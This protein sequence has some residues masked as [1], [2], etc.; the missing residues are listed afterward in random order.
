MMAQRTDELIVKQ[1]TLLCNIVLLRP[2]LLLLQVTHMWG[3]KLLGESQHSECF[4]SSKD[5][6]FILISFLTNIHDREHQFIRTDINCD[7][8]FAEP[9]I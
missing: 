2:I 8:V 6:V 4:S 9:Q 7:N 3:N 1:P 5:A